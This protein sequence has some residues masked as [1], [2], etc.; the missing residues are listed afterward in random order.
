MLAAA[1][2]VPRASNNIALFAARALVSASNADPSLADPS[3]EEVMALERGGDAT[4]RAAIAVEISGAPLWPGTAPHRIS[5]AWIELERRLWSAGDADWEV[6]I[7]WYQDR[8]A[9]RPSLG[10]EF[11][12]AVATLPNGLWEQGPKAVNAEIRRLIEV[13]TP[14]RPIPAQSAGPH[15]D[16]SP[17]HKI[18]LAASPDVDAAG[19]NLRR[20]WEQLPLVREAADDLAGRLNPNAF[21]ELARNLTAY[22]AA[23]EGQPEVIA[24]GVVFGR[25]VRLD[26]AAAAARRQIEDRLQPPLED[27]AQEA[28]DSVLTLHGPLILATAEGRELADEADRFRLTRDQQAVLRE[29]AQTLADSLK[30]SPDIVDLTVAELAEGAAETIGEGSHPERGSVYWL[31]TVRNLSTIAVPAAALG[32]FAWSIGG[33]GGNTVALGGSLLLRENERIRTAAKALGSDYDRLVDAA[34]GTVKDQI[35]LAKV[36]A[37]ARLRLLTPFRDFVTANEEPLRRI[38]AYSTNLRWMLWYIDLIVRTNGEAGAAVPQVLT[39]I[40]IVPGEPS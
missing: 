27:A 2:S 3:F 1:A 16:L 36:Q 39:S 33:F 29:D 4:A 6:W 11:D 40:R 18:G 23:I 21:P 22:R 32:A 26:N 31:A 7:E 30:N 35:D 13:H 37:I 9:G 19:N 10:E 8:L 17:A 34:F 28:L 24:W 12:I 38:A 15:F 25:G 20:L 14:P 5:S